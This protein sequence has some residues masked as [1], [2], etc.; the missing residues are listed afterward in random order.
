MGD[1]T[2]TFDDE[3]GEILLAFSEDLY[4]FDDISSAKSALISDNH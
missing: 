2:A 1:L 4:V 3:K